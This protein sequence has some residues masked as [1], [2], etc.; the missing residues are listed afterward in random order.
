MSSFGD[1]TDNRRIARN[2][3]VYMG[4]DIKP[5]STVKSAIDNNQIDGRVAR[6]TESTTRR[7]DEG[8][9]DPRRTIRVVDNNNNNTRVVREQNRQGI[10]ERRTSVS[11]NEVRSRTNVRTESR[12]RS[13]YNV[14]GR[15]T[16]YNRP[17]GS[18]R[19]REIRS[20]GTRNSNSTYRPN[21]STRSNSSGSSRSYS[22]RRSSGSSGSSS[23][24]SSGSSVSRSSGSSSGSSSTRSSGSSSGSSSRS[25]RRR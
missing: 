20:T 23:T 16:R 5:G 14:N 4:R 3:E 21:R 22:P 1:N 11:N 12:N 17:E 6:R 10:P 18:T 13:T 25:G 2:P 9:I 7:S 15:T 24:R 8:S 19:T